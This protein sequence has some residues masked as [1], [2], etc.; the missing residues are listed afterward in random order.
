MDQYDHTTGWYLP[1]SLDT[2]NEQKDKQQLEQM[3]CDYNFVK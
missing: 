2:V 1:P 3:P